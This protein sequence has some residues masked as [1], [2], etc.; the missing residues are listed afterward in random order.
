MPSSVSKKVFK[1]ARKSRSITQLFLMDDNSQAGY[2]T[3]TSPEAI[4]LAMPPPVP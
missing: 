1:A 4:G 3:I 2:Q